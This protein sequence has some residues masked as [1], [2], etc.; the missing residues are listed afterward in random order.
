M[1]QI[2]VTA[3]GLRFIAIEEG[4]GPLLLLLHGFPDTPATWDKLR[5][6]L[7]SDGWRVVTPYMRGYA[8][9]QVPD[10][11]DYRSDTLGRD[12]LGLIDAL[13]E[14]QAVVLGH[15]WGADAAYAA[16]ILD[17]ARVRLLVTVAIP[18]PASL[19]PTPRM[20]WA[21]RHFFSLRRK[22]AAAMVRRNDFAHVDELVRRWSPKWNFDPSETAAV[23]AVFRQPGSLEAALGYYRAL[24]PARRRVVQVPT[25]SFAGDDDVLDAAEFERARPLFGKGYQVIA[26]PGGHFMHRE[27]PDRFAA[28]LRKVLAPYRQA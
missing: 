9:T 12:V 1:K 10:G 3:N 24:L 14:K 23:K 25:V 26:M 20:L 27:Y 19:R 4:R 16:A 13:G 18:H 7:I 28:E 22:S 6:T 21:G 15:D 5:P 2:T 11:E 8:P 17:P